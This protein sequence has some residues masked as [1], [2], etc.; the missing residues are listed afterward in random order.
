MTGRSYRWSMAG[1]TVGGILLFAIV[2]W[3]FGH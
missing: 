2:Y 3:W 1:T